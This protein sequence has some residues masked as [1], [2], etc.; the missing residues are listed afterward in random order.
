MTPLLA[1]GAPDLIDP[2]IW[3]T[4]IGALIVLGMI[5]L[6]TATRGDGT[7]CYAA[8]GLCREACC[9]PEPQIEQLAL[10]TIDDVFG[11]EPYGEPEHQI[12]AWTPE[13]RETLGINDTMR[14]IEEVDRTLLREERL[15]FECQYGR[16]S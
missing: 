12:Q 5:L 15:V 3:W 6:A 11:L 9:E 16:Y 1:G 2:F 10:A 13:E 7:R 4:L 14:W 8:Y